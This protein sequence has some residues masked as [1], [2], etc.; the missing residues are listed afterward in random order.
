MKNTMYNPKNTLSFPFLGE[1]FTVLRADMESLWEEMV[2]ESHDTS[3]QQK[4][5]QE[6]ECKALATI[7]DEI[8]DKI[9]IEIK[10]E[11]EERLPYWAELWPSSLALAKWL[12]KNTHKINNRNCLDLGC[13]LGFT[14]IC[15]AWRG[16]N[17]LAVD[18]EERAIRLA[19]ENACANMH[20]WKNRP[21]SQGIK[22]SIFQNKND[23]QS[24]NEHISQIDNTSSYPPKTPDF[25]IMD[26]RDPHVPAKSFDFIWAGDILYER[27]FA[28]PVLTFLDYALSKDGVVWIAEPGRVI[29]DYFIDCI[30]TSE[31]KKN[32]PF[33]KLSSAFFME[34]VYFEKTQSLSPQ[35]P[36]ANVNIWEIKR[37]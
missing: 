13:G 14:A 10:D 17:V 3:T 5:I 37:T 21:L 1:N 8:Q 36:S 27:D 31:N 29:F 12:Y 26:W 6:K 15:G 34:K 32:T 25:Q 24:Q 7:A 33:P 9:E 18:Y 28:V 23:F 19:K 11:K 4:P 2:V 16:A 30:K 20:L 35:I 22:S